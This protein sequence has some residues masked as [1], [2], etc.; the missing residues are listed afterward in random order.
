MIK[1]I[2]MIQVCNDNSFNQ[3]DHNDIFQKP[4]WMMVPIFTGK[5]MMLPKMRV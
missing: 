1:M 3:D 5:G 4:E 2:M